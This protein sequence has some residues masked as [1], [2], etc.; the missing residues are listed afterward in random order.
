MGFPRQ[1][2]WSG[3]P[4]P[5]PGDL[6]DPGIELTLSVSP[7]LTGQFFTTGPPG[8]PIHCICVHIHIYS[9]FIYG[10]YYIHKYVC[11]IFFKIHSSKKEAEM[12]GLSCSL[13][14]LGLHLKGRGE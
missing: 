13:G 2:Y 7:E 10:I 1:E 3:L 14:E 8:K 6:S 5:S 4:F 9:I 12:K 11:D